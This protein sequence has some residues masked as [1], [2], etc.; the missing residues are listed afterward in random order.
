M[1]GPRTVAPD[2]RKAERSWILYDVANSAFVLIIVTAVGPLFFKDVIS[3]GVDDAV[4]TRNWGYANSV[5]SLILAVMAPV[6][7][8]L[9]D[10]RGVKKRFFTLFVGV[11]ILSTLLVPS[12]AAGRWLLF[13]ALY[14]IARTAYAGANVFYDA[15][16][17]D[18]AGGDRM[19][20]VSSSGY[21]WGYIGS[22]V[23]FLAVV[24]LILADP[25]RAGGDALPEGPG[26]IAFVIVALWWALFSVPALRHVRQRH[27]LDPGSHPVRDSLAR[28]GGTFREIRRYRRVFLFL[29][30]YFFYIDGVDT[31]ITM[32]TT[33]GR[34]NELG[35]VTLLAAVLMIQVVA[36][37]FALLYGKLAGRF[38]ARRML[39]AGIGIYIGVTLAAFFLSDV[40]VGGMRTG[41]FFALAFFAATSLGGIQALSRSMFAGL[42]PTERSA[43]FFGFYNV[44]GKFATVLG[45]FLM[46]YLTGVT[47]QPRYGT[48]G[49]LV[50]FVA[51]AAL[52]AWSSR[53][54]P[55]G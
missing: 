13:L 4:S 28:L 27:G 6:M 18:V 15:F 35:A 14:V 50:L 34:D 33:Y 8:A 23:P 19:D 39:Y 36:F 29:A 48:L 43:E 21:A 22:V 53:S 11:G 1:K 7:G 31:I 46:G 5:A 16:L 26:R 37:P 41:M 30:A 38:G 40:P 52:L 32:C 20:W 17:V 9:A 2:A 55:E 3:Y 45:P 24:G 47:G 25:S 49:V 51:G 42:I 54:A 12:A 44:F 10:Y